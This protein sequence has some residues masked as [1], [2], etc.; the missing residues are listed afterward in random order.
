MK[1]KTIVL[2]EEL[3]FK[4][5]WK[6]KISI[7]ICFFK[8]AKKYENVEKWENSKIIPAFP[9]VMQTSI[10][11]LFSVAENHHFSNKTL[12]LQVNDSPFEWHQTIV[13]DHS[14]FIEHY[15]CLSISVFILSPYA[16]REATPPTVGHAD[17]TQELSL[18]GIQTSGVLWL[19]CETCPQWPAKS[20]IKVN[21]VSST[22]KGHGV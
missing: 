17:Q 12:Y 3:T 6:V 10:K 1:F 15:K 7:F 5:L 4:Y 21:A 18:L 19:I 8:V 16:W 20:G 13:W 22:H 11:R 2:C 14:I 9:R